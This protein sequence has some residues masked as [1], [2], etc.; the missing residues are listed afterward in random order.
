MAQ[1]V[2]E[3]RLAGGT[4][5]YIDEVHRFGTDAMLLS[6]FCGIH[7]LWTA[8]DLG[9]G[10]GIIPLRWHDMGHRGPCW[11]VELDEAGTALLRRA[12]AQAG[13]AQI[14]PLTADL[15]RLPDELPRGRFDLVS[16]NPPYFTGGKVSQNPARGAARHEL[17]CTVADVCR[18]A[19]AL[20][21]DGG[22]LCLCNQPRRLA[23]CIAGMREAGIEPKRLR[24]VRQ[25]AGILPWLFLLDGRRG[26]RSGLALMPDLILEAPEGGFSAELLEI[27]HKGAPS[28]AQEGKAAQPDQRGGDSD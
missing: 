27:Y 25:R 13:A 10:C 26:G 11:A 6:E 1:R 2:S 5:V 8:C 23:D 21:R 24:F 18:A 12:A 9:S 14:H 16:C 22:R 7:R 15:C 3:H 17:H 20:L 4:P 28:F 19:A